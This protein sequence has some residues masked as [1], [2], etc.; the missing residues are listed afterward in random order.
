MSIRY[1]EVTRVYADRRVI[2]YLEP[3]NPNPQVRTNMGSISPLMYNQVGLP[4]Y[5]TVGGPPV[6]IIGG[7]FGGFVVG[8]SG[9]GFVG[10]SGGFV[11]GG[12]GGHSVEFG[13]GTLHFSN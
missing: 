5:S 2:K 10:G 6:G 3:Y 9:G 13:N 12:L 11:G 1:N 8:R 7:P 4:V